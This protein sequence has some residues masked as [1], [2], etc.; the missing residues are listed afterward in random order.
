MLSAA[1]YW[2]LPVPVPVAEELLIVN[3]EFRC[4]LRIRVVDGIGQRNGLR[5]RHRKSEYCMRIL[6]VNA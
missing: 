5:T 6:R 2:K 3:Q 1:E 4:G